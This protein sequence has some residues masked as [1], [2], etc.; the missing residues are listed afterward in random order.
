MESRRGHLDPLE[1]EL[2]AVG[3]WKPGLP[4]RTAREWKVVLAI[5]GPVFLPILSE[6]LSREKVY[7]SV[8]Q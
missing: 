6:A 5:A 8:C 3:C 1:L 7:R 2:Q 4:G